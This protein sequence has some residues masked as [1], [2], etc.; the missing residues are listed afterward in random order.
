MSS[1]HL[2]DTTETP[3]AETGTLT[4]QDG[5]LV[6]YIANQDLFASQLLGRRILKLDAYHAT[7]D[8]GTRALLVDE[9]ECGVEVISN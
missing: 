5:H 3:V 7:N 2:S 4:N 9:S 1:T 8:V 6:D